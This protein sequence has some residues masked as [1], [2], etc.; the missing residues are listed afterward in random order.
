MLKLYLSWLYWKCLWKLSWLVVAV[1]AADGAAFS[2]TD[3]AI[4]VVGCVKVVGVVDAVVVSCV[5]D[6]GGTAVVEMVIDVC[7]AE[8]PFHVLHINT[9][10]GN[11]NNMIGNR[12]Y[13]H[14]TNNNDR[15]RNN[16]TMIATP[17][18]L[19]PQHT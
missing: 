2:A 5:A 14:N 13:T 9:T 7:G 6:V 17:T 1:F 4:V 19:H 15:N 8:L 18:T 11:N 12:D 3:A 10:N 16:N